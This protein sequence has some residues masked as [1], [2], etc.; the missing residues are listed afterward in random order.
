LTKNRF[1]REAK[2]RCKMTR[3]QVISF[4]Q[5]VKFGY[6]AT[7]GADDAPRVRPIGMHTVYGDHLYFFTFANTR[8]VAEIESNPR[9]EVVWSRPEERSQ[10]RIRGEMVAEEDA[11]L[12]QRFRDDNPI[13]ARMLPE[14]AQ[15][16]FRLYR[17]EPEVVEIAQGFV[18]YTDI[19]W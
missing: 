17:L 18:P 7:M 2:R 6:L 3:D 8:K 16:L 13:V 11:A 9:V 14:A 1:S 19:D 12:Q 10:V 15:H 4:I 5:Q